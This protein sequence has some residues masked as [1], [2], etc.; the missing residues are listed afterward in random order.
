LDLKNISEECLDFLRKVL[1]ENPEKRLNAEQA[2]E[3][4]WFKVNK[5]TKCFLV[6]TE[7]LLL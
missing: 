6:N 4:K 5:N 1:Q 2:L 3:H 7:D